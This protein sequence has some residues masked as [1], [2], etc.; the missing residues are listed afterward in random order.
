MTDVKWYDVKWIVATDNDGLKVL[1][2]HEN[3]YKKLAK[4]TQNALVSIEQRNLVI[5]YYRRC[6]TDFNRDT[7][8]D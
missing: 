3:E 2:L 4:N 1:G 8:R 7:E 6:I 5:D